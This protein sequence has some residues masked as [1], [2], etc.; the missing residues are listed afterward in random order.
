MLKLATVLAAGLSAAAV[1]V[2][3][4][5]AA[6]EPMVLKFHH[7]LGPKAP[8]Q[9]HMIEPWVKKVEA[10]SGGKLKIEIY[11]SMALGGT[12]PQLIKQVRDGVVDFVWTVTGYTAGQFPRSEV[13]E[14]PTVFTNNTVATNLAM[15]DL[16]AEYLA[17]EYADVKVI[18]LHVHAG[19]GI[20]T[21]DK[22]I[23]KVEDLAGMKMRIPTRTGAWILEALGAN[24]VGMPVP[25][26]PQALAKKVVDGALIPW[27][28]MP[29]LKIQELTKYQIEGPNH[30]RFGT[31]TFVIAM[32]KAK[33]E[34]LPAALQKAIDDN[35]GEE[36]AREVGRVW[37]Q[38]ELVG[39]DVAL[40]DGNELITISEAEMKRFEARLA[41]VV[42][43]WIEDVKGQ[44]VDGAKLVAAARAAIAK[45]AMEGNAWDSV[46]K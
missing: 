10:S 20:H 44:G 34:S 27:E 1:V 31:A 17:P 14:L 26:L 13:F 42:D 2:A 25:Q 32:N 3:G 21:V 16:F 11:P 43:R 19:Q 45:R 36:F 46:K 6:Q 37:T 8:A 23:H 12:P 24:P 9:V 41:P 35:S 39:L 40:K 38:S 28:I 22:P 7:L 30:V 33:Y 5:A 4:P 29:P 15:R 18:A